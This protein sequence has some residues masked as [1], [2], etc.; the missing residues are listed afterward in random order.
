[1][2]PQTTALRWLASL[3]ASIDSDW[4]AAHVASAPGRH[5]AAIAALGNQ[6]AQSAE[7]SFRKMLREELAPKATISEDGIATV[8]IQGPIAHAPDVWDMYLDGVEDSRSILTMVNRVSN[9]NSVKGVL[10]DINSPGGMVTGGTDIAEA[11]GAMARKKPVVAW[12][13]G[14]MASLA[15]Q[16]GSQASEVITSGSASVG[17]IG[18]IITFADMSKAL[19]AAGIKLEIIT[20]KEAEFK[21]IQPGVPLTDSQRSYLQERAQ[22]AFDEFASMVKSK[23]P[24]AK[25]SSMR[26]QVFWGKEAKSAGLVDRVGDMAFAAGVLRQMVRAS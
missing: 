16:I 20:N 18:T 13:G 6:D 23:R 8:P 17:S 7:T 5:E 1:M 15:Y 10:L 11:V 2:K 3:I 22:K 25:D 26:G 21:G 4:L 12:S 14:M 24:S 9:D 19:D